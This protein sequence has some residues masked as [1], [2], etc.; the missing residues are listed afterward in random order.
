MLGVKRA[1][2]AGAIGSYPAVMNA[3]HD[4][5]GAPIASATPRDMPGTPEKLWAA[6]QHQ[7]SD[8]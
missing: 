2:E 8:R 3:L 1:G 7:F 6:A 4:A 5:L